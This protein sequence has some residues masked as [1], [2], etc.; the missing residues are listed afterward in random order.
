MNELR[1]L[2]TMAA[3]GIGFRDEPYKARPQGTTLS[4]E[5]SNF[6]R[7]QREERKARLKRRKAAQRRNRAA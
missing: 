4:G 5:R 1:L 6:T 7:R 3:L 2:Y